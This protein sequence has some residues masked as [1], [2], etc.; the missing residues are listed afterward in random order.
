[1]NADER[2]EEWNRITERIIGCAY[3][4]ANTLGCGFLEKVYENALLH[5][6]RKAGF[7]VAPQEQIHVYYDGVIVGE[8]F[9]D[10]LVERQVILEIKAVD[11]IDDVHL[12]QCLNYL[13]ATGLHVALIINFARP[14]LQIKRV[15]R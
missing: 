15:V 2:R 4:V 9:A 6:L 14:K 1:M 13:K 3:T 12:A 7:D 11:A 10:L 5:E 8:Y